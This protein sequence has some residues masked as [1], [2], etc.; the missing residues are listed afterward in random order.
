MCVQFLAL[1]HIESSHCK[2][3]DPLILVSDCVLYRHVGVIGFVEEAS[4]QLSLHQILW[5]EP[6][7]LMKRVCCIVVGVG[8]DTTNRATYL[9]TYL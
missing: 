2:Q 4:L 1:S 8:A 9:L 5:W 6:W 7:Y 3:E